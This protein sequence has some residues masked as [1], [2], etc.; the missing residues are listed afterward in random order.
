MTQRGAL[1]LFDI[2]GTLVSPNGAG[3]RALLAAG[4]ALFGD[5]FTVD[6]LDPSGKL[7]PAIFLEL[8]ERH[9]HLDLRSR[10]ADFLP[11]Y[12]AA[13]EREAH[14]MRALPGAAATVARLAGEPGVTLGILTGNYASVATLKLETTGLVRPGRVEPFSVRAC[15]DEAAD[16]AALVPLA[17]TRYLASR[18]VTQAPSM[19]LVGDTPRDVEAGRAHDVPAVGVATG[20][21]CAEALTQAGAAQ[22]P[23]A[24]WAATSACTSAV[25]SRVPRTPSPPSTPPTAP[26]WP[27]CP[28]RGPLRSTPPLPRPAPRST[29]GGACRRW[30]ARA[31]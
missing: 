3:S 4:S 12:L 13:L 18:G 20:R 27:R 31:G 10:A 14:R 29:T 21:W 2:D 6:G 17:R 22:T 1:V 5:A 9:P 16:R 25:P 24:T 19:L 26:P 8:A 30:S 28:S 23:K 11:L 7:D 15:G